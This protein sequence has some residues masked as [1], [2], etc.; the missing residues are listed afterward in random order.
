MTKKKKDKRAVK[1][2]LAKRVGNFN[3]HNALGSI[4]LSVSRDGCVCNME[5]EYTLFIYTADF[6]T[7]QSLL[8][9][10]KH[11]L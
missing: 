5:K 4:Q 10:G 1:F 9:I 8:K 6:V 2:L 11:I 3:T 7:I